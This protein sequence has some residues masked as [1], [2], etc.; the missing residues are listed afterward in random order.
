M[1]TERTQCF[2]QGTDGNKCLFYSW[3][4]LIPLSICQPVCRWLNN[5]LSCSLSGSPSCLVMISFAST[6]LQPAHWTKAS[7]QVN[8]QLGL[9]VF[10]LLS[11]LPFCQ[12]PSSSSLSLSLTIFGSLSFPLHPFYSCDLAWRGS[13]N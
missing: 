7:I 11:F 3:F 10:L 9:F 4:L 1:D 6:T 2:Q 8:P 13:V 12:A 5:V